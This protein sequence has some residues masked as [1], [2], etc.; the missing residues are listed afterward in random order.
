MYS[1]LLKT[2]GENTILGLSPACRA[3][4]LMLWEDTW[5]HQDWKEPPQT[6]GTPKC[7]TKLCK[8]ELPGGPR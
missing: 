2:R 3:L 4:P 5:R 8:E 7:L 6:L 1:T